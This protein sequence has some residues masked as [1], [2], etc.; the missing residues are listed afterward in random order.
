MSKEQ[1]MLSLYMPMPPTPTTAAGTSTP[2]TC[3]IKCSQERI[4]RTVASPSSSGE[5]FKKMSLNQPTPTKTKIF[6][7][8]VLMDKH[9][10]MN[11]IPPKKRRTFEYYTGEQYLRKSTLITNKIPRVQYPEGIMTKISS[12]KPVLNQSSFHKRDLFQRQGRFVKSVEYYEESSKETIE[13]VPL[14]IASTASRTSS[15]MIPPYEQRTFSSSSSPLVL[16]ESHSP[17]SSSYS[18]LIPTPPPPLLHTPSLTPPAAL[19]I[20]SLVEPNNRRL[21]DFKAGSFDSNNS[22]DSSFSGSDE[23]V[24]VVNKTKTHRAVVGR[25]IK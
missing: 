20:P 6:K 10:S 8:T 16:Y 17:S 23:E 2:C 3:C 18:S 15:L 1:D 13:K 4:Y 14:T 7:P 9:I 25:A 5:F 12:E 24:Q 21:N 19:R 22:I 11:D